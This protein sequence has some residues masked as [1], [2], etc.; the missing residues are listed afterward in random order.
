MS[1]SVPGPSLYVG[2]CQSGKT[3]LALNRAIADSSR[4]N[5]PL[6]I[7]DSFRAGNF[8]GFPHSPTVRD[9]LSILFASRSTVAFFPGGVTGDGPGDVARLCAG[10]RAG[11]RAVVLLDELRPWITPGRLP[12]PL[13]LLFRSYAHSRVILHVTTQSPS[14]LPPEVYQSAKR[15]FVFRNDSKRAL[16]LIAGEFPSADLAGVPALGR[17]RF[18]ELDREF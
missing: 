13:S 10:L 8:S 3:T 4:W 11:G 17:G 9:S 12:A 5:S 2:V 18:V 16:D 14:D 6:M 15:V 7:V 1:D